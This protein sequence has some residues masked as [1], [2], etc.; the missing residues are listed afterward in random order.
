M[1]VLKLGKKCCLFLQGDYFIQRILN[2]SPETN[3]ATLK[4]ATTRLSEMTE[5]CYDH[6]QSNDQEI[7][8]KTQLESLKF[9][10]LYLVFMF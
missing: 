6:T 10:N 8:S 4:T 2:Y 9:C 1:S 3:S 7:F 5:Q